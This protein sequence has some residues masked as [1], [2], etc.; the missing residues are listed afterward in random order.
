MKRTFEDVVDLEQRPGAGVRQWTR[1]V[2]LQL[3]RVQDANYRHRL[4]LSPNEDEQVDDADA[5]TQL[6]SDVYFLVLAIRRVLLFHDLL[7]RRIDD[8]RLSAARSVFISMAS[9]A[10]AFRDFYE[11]LDAYLLDAPDKRVKFPGRASPV[12]MSTW[13]ADNVVIAF[14]DR[15][16]DV[17]VAGHAAVALGEATEEVWLQSLDTLKGSRPAKEPP[18]EDGVRSKLVVQLGVSSVVGSVEENY[19]VSTGFLTGVEVREFT[20]AEWAA[21]ED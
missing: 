13:A 14:A 8:S 20:A 15:R 1:A 21:E 2:R 12:L 10:K 7:A 6:H 4:N 16:L 9:E 18:S 3:G 19:E 5:E 11:H 17:T